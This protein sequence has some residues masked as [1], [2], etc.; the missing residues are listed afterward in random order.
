MNCKRYR[1]WITDAAAG[2]LQEGRRRE[3]ENHT[4]ECGACRQEFQ[5]VRTL[6]KAIDLAVTAQATGEPSPRLMEQVRQRIREQA[7][8]APSWSAWDARWVQAVACAAVLIVAASL[9]SLWPRTA[10]PRESA[11]NSATPPSAQAD[12]PTAV[13]G[14]APPAVAPQRNEPAAALAPHIHKLRGR[15]IERR[16]EVPEVIVQPGQMKAVMLFVRVMNSQQANA[17]K[18]LADLKAADRPIEIQPLEI[19]PLVIVPLETP[20]LADDKSSESTPDGG[21]KRF[22]ASEKSR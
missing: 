3:L 17:A 13:S 9:W 16:A 19:K 4:R 7:S 10:T 2:G 18:L 21:D 15:G 14:A 11:A 22:I 12:R 1:D 20:K 5:R 8:V 6:L